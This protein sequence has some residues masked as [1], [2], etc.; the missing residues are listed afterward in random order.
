MQI[1]QVVEALLKLSDLLVPAM[2]QAC[3]GSAETTSW[4]AD[5]AG[6]GGAAQAVRFA[7]ANHTEALSGSAETISWCADPAGC[8]G[9]AQAAQTADANHTEGLGSAE[10]ISWC[11]DP[12][13]CGGRC[14]SSRTCW[15]QPY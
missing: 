10:T 14:S 4:R 3:L 13:G 11:A 12:A 9:A 5:P 1:S 6:G 8:G 2:T 15:C 7:G